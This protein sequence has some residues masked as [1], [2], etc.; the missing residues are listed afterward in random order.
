[1]HKRKPVTHFPRG[2]GTRT[3]NYEGSLWRAGW[4]QKYVVL[5]RG[6][7]ST[8]TLKSLKKKKSRIN[9]SS[10]LHK[11]NNNNNWSSFTPMITNFKWSL[12]TSRQFNYI[13]T[14]DSLA[15]SLRCLFC[16]FSLSSNL[17]R[18]LPLFLPSSLSD[19]ELASFSL[20]KQRQSRERWVWVPV[21]CCPSCGCG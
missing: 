1:M 13:S 6:H 18:L 15:Y 10:M 21:L 3:R 19:D 8:T 20:R 11:N 17:Q 5:L 7:D 12:R 2:R 16:T 9:K 14:A 4:S